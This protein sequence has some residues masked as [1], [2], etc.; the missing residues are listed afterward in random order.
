LCI[1]EKYLQAIMMSAFLS[2]KNGSPLSHSKYESV[3]A[4]DPETGEKSTENFKP[5]SVGL[6]TINGPIVSASDPWYGIKGTIEAAQELQLLDTDPNIIGSVFFMESGGGS[7]YALKPI[8]DVMAGLTKPVVCYSK[9]ILASAA[10]GIVANCDHIMMYHP[11][12]IVGSLGTMYSSSDLQPMFEKWGMKF[13]EYYAT[14]SSL[15]NKTFTDARKGDGSALINNMLNPMNDVFLGNIQS[16]RGHLI[17]AKSKTVYKG[18]TYMADPQALQLG[19][20]DSIGNLNDA[21]AM[22]VKLANGECES[23]LIPNS[24]NNMNLKW[25][26]FK[27]L[28]ALKGIEAKAI[29]EE[30]IDAVHAELEQEGIKGITV[31]TD[32]QVEELTNA[33]PDP[34]NATALTA[35]NN[36][37]ADLQNKL[38]AANAAKTKA[39]SDLV[40]ANAAKIKAE[41]ELVAAN[42][43]IVEL[44]GQPA[45][46]HTQ[47]QQTQPDPTPGAVKNP[48]TY[49]EA[50][51]KLAELRAQHG[52]KPGASAQGARVKGAAN[53]YPALQK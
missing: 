45:A 39:E 53:F 49:S 19:L 11:Q 21:I 34:A 2:F 5:G 36:K 6:V 43:K 31:M 52:L 46:E 10:Y 24:Q 23:A 4:V 50:D 30:Q 41:G 32:E 8:C 13:F 35:A 28:L 38:D 44:G 12:G 37:V 17:D 40:L 33:A 48:S 7:A 1:E 3:Y 29:T 22:V 15:K 47:S 20:I 25:N 51:Q 9:Q 27:S 16:M 26:K 14:D 42:A 18:E